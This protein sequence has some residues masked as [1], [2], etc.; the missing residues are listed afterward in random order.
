VLVLI[1][2]LAPDY[3]ERRGALREEHL[4]LIMA[5]HERGDLQQAGALSEPFDRALLVW[6]TDDESVVD[7]FI[8]ADP[9]VSNG[10]VTSWSV[11]TWNTVITTD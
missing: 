10:L 5:A 1:Y 11:R 4:A 6:S 3:L 9:Y 2:E 7:A 8:A